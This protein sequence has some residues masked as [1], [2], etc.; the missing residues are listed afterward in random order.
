MKEFFVKIK[1]ADIRNILAI[2]VTLGVFV[3][4]YL[5]VIKE[6]PKDNHDIVISAVSF[7]FGGGF[8]AVTSYF[9]GASKGDKP[10]DENQKL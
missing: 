4:M 9:F 10:K 3:L 8:G 1:E 7:V 6:I 2:I 5:L